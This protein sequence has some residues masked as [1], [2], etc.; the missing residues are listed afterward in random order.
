M[1]TA[2][3][4]VQWVGIPTAAAMLGLTTGRIVGLVRRGE[5]AVLHLPRSQRMVDIIELRRLY[6]AAYTPA[7]GAKV[8]ADA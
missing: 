6:D 1:A 7:R 2:T 8:K 5:I 4:G 3:T